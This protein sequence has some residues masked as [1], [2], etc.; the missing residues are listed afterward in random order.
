MS[1]LLKIDKEYTEWI[2]KLSLR[3]KK[4]QIKAAVKVNSEMLNFYWSVGEDILIQKAESKWGEGFYKGLSQDLQD[5]FPDVKGFSVRN[6][7]YMK[8]MYEVFSKE[9]IFTPQVVAQITDTSKDEIT[10]Q[11]VAQFIKDNVC[12]IPWGHIRF[13]LDK[14]YDSQKSFFFVRQVIENNWSRAVL[15]NFL[16]T[17]LYERQGKAITNFRTTLP[18]IESDLAQEIT[19]DPYNFDFVGITSKYNEKEL[20]DALIRNIQKFLMELGTGFAYMG[21]E[22][23]LMIGETEQ[24]LDML[25]YNV[26]VHSYV[27]VEVKTTKFEPSFLGQLGAYVVA[28]DHILKKAG[29]NKTIGLLICKTKDDVFARYSLEASSQPI[30]ISE[31]E[32]SK[33]FPKE[34]KSSLPSIEDIEEQL[35]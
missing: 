18:A 14:K 7:Q 20:K 27:V 6:L 8:Q 29:D 22:Y 17:D 2:N 11:V 28:V 35:K 23:R 33:I 31:Y 5:I 16:D 32:L 1:K 19:K 24:F 25:F 30:G 13:I 10:P 21:R 12:R 26:D 3:F 9:T 15:L 4:S 34:F